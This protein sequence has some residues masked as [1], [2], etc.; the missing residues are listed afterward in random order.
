M[1]MR[2]R[3]P[4]DWV[5]DLD[6]RHDS[7]NA[8]E[9]GIKYHQAFELV[10]DSTRSFS[11]LDFQLLGPEDRLIELEVK[12]K[13]QPLSTGWQELRPQVEPNN[14]FVLD[15]L[16]LRKIMDA[17]RYAFLLV[18]DVPGARWVLWSSGDLLVASRVRHARRLERSHVS[19]MKGKLLFDLSEGGAES[20]SLKEAL[21]RLAEMAPHV[22]EWWTDIAPWPRARADR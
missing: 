16:A 7:E 3:R 8:V 5:V 6:R 1:K 22:D 18:R 13:L 19:R 12:A 14:L 10:S 11:R 2:E 9:R 20:P 4:S 15:E 21:D 17:G